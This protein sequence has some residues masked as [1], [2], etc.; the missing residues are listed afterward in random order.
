MLKISIFP[1]SEKDEGLRNTNSL[2]S[3]LE[4]EDC[5]VS[6]ERKFEPFVRRR[7]NLE[8]KDESELYKN[9]DVLIIL[10]GDGSIMR[11]ARK[12]SSY[13]LPII[14]INLGRLGYLAELETDEIFKLKELFKGNYLIEKRMMLSVEMIKKDGKRE[15]LPPALNDAVISIGTMPRIVQILL[16][17][18]DKAVKQY[19]ADGIIATTPTGSTAYSLAAGGPI[20][21]PHMNCICVTPVCPQS[22]Y[23]KPMVF[24]DKSCLS[25]E[26]EKRP[27]FDESVY[28]TIDGSEGRKIEVGD[29][30]IIKK[31]NRITRMI[32]IKE[33]SFYKLIH[34]KMSEI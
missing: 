27:N 26:I 22:L 18:D 4:C 21:D 29:K 28:L 34:D 3:F 10:G 12:A 2:L 16:S 30:I 8:Y 9:K 14:G 23:D 6:M 13:E 31:S 25:F 17:C 5:T 1:N 20:I 24:S 15:V 11:V 33:S 19:R 32:R 7:K